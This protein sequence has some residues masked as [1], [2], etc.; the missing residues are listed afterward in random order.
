VAGKTRKEI[1]VIVGISFHTVSNHI[2]AMYAKAD[3]HNGV[4]LAVR[5][6]HLTH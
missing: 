5:I 2:R 1:A 3:A 6:W 4:M